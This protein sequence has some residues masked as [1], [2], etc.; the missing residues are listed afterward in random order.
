M[1]LYIVSRWSPGFFSC[2]IKQSQKVWVVGCQVHLAVQQYGICFNVQG[3]SNHLPALFE[4][5]SLY[6]S[7]CNSQNARALDSYSSLCLCLCPRKGL[8]LQLYLQHLFSFLKRLFSTSL[9]PR[10][11]KTSSFKRQHPL[12]IKHWL[13]TTQLGLVQLL[14]FMGPKSQIVDSK[15]P[16]FG[17]HRLETEF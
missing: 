7:A 10:E 17:I 1:I 8:L 9:K 4:T 6:Y 15:S 16:T 11:P 2:Y 12:R 13:H 5:S 14:P 3:V